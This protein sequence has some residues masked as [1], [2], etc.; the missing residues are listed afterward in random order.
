MLHSLNIYK[1]S[2]IVLFV[3]DS[4]H[5]VNRSEILGIYFEAKLNSTTPKNLVRWEAIGVDGRHGEN[6][7]LQR[8]V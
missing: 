5:C 2:R 3:F 6:A 4:S 7:M 8:D 1:T